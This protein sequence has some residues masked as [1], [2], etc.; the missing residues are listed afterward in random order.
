MRDFADSGLDSTFGVSLRD[1]IR[2]PEKQA[3][4]FLRNRRNLGDEAPAIGATPA[5]GVKQMAHWLKFMGGA[6][7][8]L[9]LQ[10]PDYVSTDAF[11]ARCETALY[12]ALKLRA[13]MRTGSADWNHIRDEAVGL[14]S[15]QRAAVVEHVY[16]RVLGEL[17]VRRGG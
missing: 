2:S 12:E 10:A 9:G 6:A 4:S 5:E 1:G 7:H 17:N 8:F 13:L 3:L 16:A 14:D 11:D 15:H